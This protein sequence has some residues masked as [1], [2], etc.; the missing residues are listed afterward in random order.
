MK[1]DSD[2]KAIVTKMKEKP[3][4]D[5]LFGKGVVRVDGPGPPTGTASIPTTVT[6]RFIRR[7]LAGSYAQMQDLAR[8]LIRRGL[9]H[10]R[11]SVTSAMPSR[12]QER[13]T[14]QRER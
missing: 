6:G 13:L 14:M 4:D 8:V 12:R 9:F 5:A 11:A 10:G 3:T 1:S 7:G 2:G